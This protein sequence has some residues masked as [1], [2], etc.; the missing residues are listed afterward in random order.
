MGRSKENNA[1]NIAQDGCIML[2]LLM[3][4]DDSLAQLYVS[5]DTN[6]LSPI[7]LATVGMGLSLPA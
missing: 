4:T 5:L 3:G 6:A 2:L 1:A 7:E